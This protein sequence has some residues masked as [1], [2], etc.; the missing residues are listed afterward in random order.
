MALRTED[1]HAVT[2]DSMVR[3]RAKMEQS[4]RA[5]LEG[6]DRWISLSFDIASLEVSGDLARAIVHQHADRMA[7][8][9]RPPG[10]PRRDLGHSTRDLAENAVEAQDSTNGPKQR[11]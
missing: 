10:A 7:L 4:T 1:F 9:R 6:I 2:P 8:R 5:L 3:D 11:S